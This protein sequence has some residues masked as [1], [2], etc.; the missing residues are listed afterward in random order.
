[1]E[2]GSSEGEDGRVWIGVKD[3]PLLYLYHT[4]T[5]SLLMT[6]DCTD[7]IL[8]VLRGKGSLCM[9]FESSL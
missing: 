8:D 2:R 7:T 1:M 3:T 5:G 9:Q 6:V 4:A